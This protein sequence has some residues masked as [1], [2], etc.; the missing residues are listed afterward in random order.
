M[1]EERTVVEQ[2]VLNGKRMKGS[3]KSGKLGG[4]PTLQNNSK[5]PRGNLL[6]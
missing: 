4:L 5:E 3:L 2:E 1:K 6:L